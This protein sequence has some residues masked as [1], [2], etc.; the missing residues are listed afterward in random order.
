M[1]PKMLSDR[2]QRDFAVPGGEEQNEDDPKCTPSNLQQRARK[3]LISLLIFLCDRVSRAFGEGLIGVGGGDQRWFRLGGTN[4]SGLGAIR[5]ARIAEEER[6]M[7]IIGA[8]VRTAGV[9]CMLILIIHCAAGPESAPSEQGISLAAVEVSGWQREYEPE[10]YIGD[11]LFELINGGAEVYHG[12]GFVQA[13]AM[14]YADGGG[15]SISLEVFEMKDVEGAR[16]IYSD[17]TGG[18]GEPLEIGDE[19]AGEDYYL[20]FRSGRFLVTITGF[21]SEPETTAGILL[22]AR[23]V[24]EQL[25]GVS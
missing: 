23:A 13:L 16:N 8:A 18:S 19:G 6:K 4:R 15:R 7:E 1:P 2:P 22:L 20:N 10:I 5:R 25:G 24:A 12:F 14:Q 3:C 21:D 11:A 9:L 17:K